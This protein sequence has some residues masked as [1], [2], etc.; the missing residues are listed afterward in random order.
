MFG[1]SDMKEA[2][3][4]GNAMALPIGVPLPKR[5]KR[6]VLWAIRW[7]LENLVVGWPASRAL[8]KASKLEQ[9]GQLPEAFRA[10]LRALDILHH[11]Y[12]DYWNPLLMEMRFGATLRLDRLATAMGASMPREQIE[13]IV[14]AFRTTDSLHEVPHH[15][16]VE[17]VL[18]QWEAKLGRGAPR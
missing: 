6:V 1:A 16:D 9:N 17:R 10:V 4:K 12:L 13:E 7:I 3:G 2:P 11:R 14:D 5:R 8:R 18:V 15:S